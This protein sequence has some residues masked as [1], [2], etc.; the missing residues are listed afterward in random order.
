MLKPTF[1]KVNGYKK[2]K[3]I[4]YFV[5]FIF[6]FFFFFAVFIFQKIAENHKYCKNFWSQKLFACKVFS[7]KGWTNFSLY[8]RVFCG[9]IYLSAPFEH[10]RKWTRKTKCM[11]D[12][13][14]TRSIAFCS[15]SPIMNFQLLF[16]IRFHQKL[17]QR[18]FCT[19]NI[20]WMF[21]I[22]RI[23]KN[24]FYFLNAFVYN[25]SEWFAE[26]MDLY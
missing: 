25:G 24:N 14:P 8:S 4:H 20:V 22:G 3:K 11:F 2:H 10:A 17:W 13:K 15:F 9:Q 19:L 1:F 7:Y 16:L 6:F 23:S 26:S 21:K 18:E 12:Q 5:V